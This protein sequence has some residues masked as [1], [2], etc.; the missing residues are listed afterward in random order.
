[1]HAIE[2]ADH[3]T[4]GIVGSDRH[5]SVRF[6]VHA[7]H[8]FPVVAAIMR[9][10]HISRLLIDY[11]PRGNVNVFRVLRINSD[12]IKNVVV[13]TQMGQTRPVVSPVG[14]QEKRSGAG[15][16]T[17]T[18]GTLWVEAKAPNVASVRTQRGPLTGPE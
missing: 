15:S 13:V 5:G 2:R 8:R 6:A 18:V 14:R 10:V 1:E 12:V 17:D 9:A 4:F 3:Q 11:A 16:K 7:G